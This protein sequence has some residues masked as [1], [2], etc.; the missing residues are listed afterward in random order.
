MKPRAAAINLLRVLEV[1]PDALR[2][3]REGELIPATSR[4]PTP[5]EVESEDI[6]SLGP[7]AFPN[8]LRR[9]LSAEAREHNL[10]R[11]GIRVASNIHAPDGGED[12]R[13]SWRGGPERTPFL[14]SRLCQFQLK[15]GKISPAQAAKDVL[16]HEAKVKPMVRSVLE[17]GGNYIMFCGQR[18][19]EQQVQA[20][21]RAICDA[22][23]KA[24]LSIPDQLIGFREADQIAEWVNSHQ[25]VALWV[26]E[27]V[28][29]GTPGGFTSWNHWMGRSEHSMPWVED[30]RLAGLT[31]A[32][33]SSVTEPGTVLRV[34]GL[35]GIGKSRL[36]LEGLKR[37][38]E[39][40]ISG[41]SLR[42]YVMY[43]V[44]SE[45]GAEAIHPIVEKLAV[46]GGRAIVVVDDCDARSHTILAGMVSRS[47]SR[48]S[49]VTIDNETPSHI[50]ADTFKI[51]EAPATVVESIVD[52]AA[53]RL[54]DVDRQRLARFSRGFPEI[55]IRIVRESD[56]RG[57]LTY[58][59]D[60][61]LIDEFVCGRRPTEQ[62]LLLQSAQLLAAFGPVRID[63]PEECLK[64]IAKLGRH[65][66][67]NDLYT[68]IQRLVQ[69]GVVKLR[70]ELG[71]IQPRPIA[72]RLAERQWREWDKKKWDQVLSGDIGT[73]DRK[74]GPAPHDPAPTAAEGDHG[75][76]S[77]A[78][79]GR[80]AELNA[81]DVAN[82]VAVHVCRENGQLDQPD[83]IVLPSRA[84]VLSSLA[85]INAD[86][87]AAH[88]GRSL[89]R[90][91]DLRQL[92][93]DVHR[94]LI[95]TL[96]T[97]AFRSSTF[98]VGARL[99]L[100][101]ATSG[102]ASRTS[103]ASRPFVELFSPILGGT[104][105]DGDVR[106]R[107][108]DQAA[109]MADAAQMNQIVEALVEGCRLGGY[110]WT[111]GPE[112]QG[113]R[114]ALAAW[115][116]NS[117]QERRRYIAGCVNRLGRLA[118]RDD[119]VG[120][121]ARSDLGMTISS[122]LRHGFAEPVEEA[123]GRVVRAGCYWS[124]ALR[125]MKAV[126]EYNSD[127]IDNKT[128]DRVRC[129][130]DQLEPTSLA[131]RVRV[132]VTEPPMP[133][134]TETEATMI[135]AQ[136]DRHRA[137]V[138]ALTYDLLV[139]PPTLR[140]LLPELSRGRQ[141]M[142]DELGESLAKSAP[143]PLEW[144]E[145]IVQA[146]LGTPASER[147]YDL[148]SG[149]VGGLPAELHD[150]AE[151]FK[152]RAVSSPDLAPA[153]P[154]ICRRAGITEKDVTRA[155]NALDQ[156]S[157]SPWDLHHWAFTWMLDRVSPVT[158]A[159]LLDAL[160]DH[161]AP[162]FALAVTILSRILLDEGNRTDRS[163]TH[164]FEFTDFR[165]QVL[166]VVQNAGRWSKAD[167]RPEPNLAVSDFT[168]NVVEHHFQEIVMRMLDG[169]REDPDAQHTALALARALVDG[170]HDAWINSGFIKASP[171][172]TRLM[173]GF[174][175]VSW[176][177]IGKGIVA[178]ARFA[179]RMRY[180][181][182]RPYSFGRDV[183]PPILDLPEETLF[184]W[185]DANP[186]G[187][188]A[189]VAR[190]VPILSAEGGDADDGFLHPVISRLL[191]S[192]GERDDVQEALESNVRTYSW[193]GSLASYYCRYRKPF[194]RLRAHPN[195]RVQ[196]WAEK[197]C[198]QIAR[199]IA[200]ERIRDEEREAQESWLG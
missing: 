15:T 118:A 152:T 166:K 104:E 63:P 124:L 197:M 16:V 98:M 95:R 7:S 65:R 112:I 77:V 192:F 151:A 131:E 32:L 52:Q 163:R 139:D 173:S 160:I 122:L 172:L 51:D 11:D 67:P 149:F 189:F 155:V 31:R 130:V 89:D 126:L 93:D 86:V 183:R 70:G 137:I 159:R 143:S 34:I 78:A 102:D 200:S 46:S 196:Q 29:L 117:T 148:L 135:S 188:P 133:G 153:F 20:R 27:E 72:V 23:A 68:G 14:P 4:V 2:V 60:D 191:D 110:S 13:I 199:C 157:M 41:R 164:F 141:S 1:Y 33:R 94:P 35:S 36:C 134:M 129:L 47:E 54:Q 48:L 119:D 28:G 88:I 107:F 154:K 90:L 144:L 19:N 59:A 75:D 91:G 125:Q 64:G 42:D 49:L 80:L 161:S 6:V 185:C 79:A 156:G 115:Y 22:L 40:A 100:R 106:L 186:D 170:D 25:P 180:V 5:F 45:A 165:P 97:I 10:P 9:L 83:E 127:L 123:V 168:P 38:G 105:A 111:I 3:L 61:H 53:A 198:G 57:H 82:D 178:D 99:M 84:R 194:E 145:P 30:P 140:E 17:Q 169:G 128:A 24:G 87:V 142:A 190:C 62:A 113:S 101:L 162:S 132:F 109:D 167:Y 26:R 108:L 182:G 181:L 171:V 146:V 76:L 176:Q 96:R 8:L 187:A 138:D 177:L 193:S 71:T 150:E 158:V 74:T 37:V 120:A 44:R 21:Q 116:P 92:G 81:T 114:K 73:E 43:A 39:D 136:L 175:E 66:S 69:R 85:E 121:K 50:D 147:N 58:P 18:Y 179:S 184:A 12:G 195:F 56:S 103:E 55:A 174:P